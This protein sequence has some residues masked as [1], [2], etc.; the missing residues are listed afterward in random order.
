MPVEIRE[1]QITAIVQDSPPLL[2]NASGP[3]TSSANID[4]II[5]ACVEQVMEILKQ[6]NER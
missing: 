6:K 4:E 3:S 1:L 2:T 5:A